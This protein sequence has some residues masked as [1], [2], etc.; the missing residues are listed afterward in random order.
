MV[1]S[2][3][4]T[5]RLVTDQVGSVRLVVDTTSGAVVE[6]IDRD[7]FGNILSDSA[8]GTQ[9]FG[10]AGGVTDGDTGITRLGTRDFDS[11][12]RTWTSKDPLTIQGG[13]ANLYLYSGGDPINQID[14]TGREW[15][16]LAGALVGGGAGLLGSAGGQALAYAATHNGSLEGFRVNWN[17]AFTSAAWGAA[18]GFVS[19][20][21]AATTRGAVL[22]GGVSSL[23]QY[24]FGHTPCQ[25]TLTGAA[26][27][28]GLGMAG[29][30]I[31]GSFSKGPQEYADNI[32]LQSLDTN[33]LMARFNLEQAVLANVSGSTFLRNLA[34]A[35]VSG[36]NP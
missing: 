25:R 8:Q 24:Y 15:L 30:A 1:T 12:T 11:A 2:A 3:G 18:T 21:A 33:R 6:R 16:N 31:G 19:P 10:F 28:L 35:T 4:A 26:L 29:G 36:L 5:Y 17:D 22:L 20:W 23:A 32:L 7:E 27:S 14:P 34:G 13:S 9:P